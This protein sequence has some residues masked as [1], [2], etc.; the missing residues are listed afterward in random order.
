MAVITKEE[1]KKEFMEMLEEDFKSFCTLLNG[2]FKKKRVEE[3][4]KVVLTCSIPEDTDVV[5]HTYSFEKGRVEFSVDGLT[6][7]GN[8]GYLKEMAEVITYF[9]EEGIDLRRGDGA[10]NGITRDAYNWTEMKN[11]REITIE[12]LEDRPAQIYIYFKRK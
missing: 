2:K 7:S 11:V 8:L 9:F 10:I 12:F 4:S 6:K 5:F 1:E 3:E